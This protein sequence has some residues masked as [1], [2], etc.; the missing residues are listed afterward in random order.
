M[1]GYLVTFIIALIASYLLTPLIRRVA[2]EFK[3]M[4]KPS[5]SEIKTHLVATPYLG[6]VAIYFSFVIAL[7]LATIFLHLSWE[8][9]YIVLISGTIIMFMGLIDDISSLSVYLRFIIQIVI[10]FVLILFNIRIMFISPS[11][12]GMFL[13][14]LWVVGITNAFNIIDIMDGL[15]AGVAVIASMALLF[16]ALPTEQIYVNF[17]A[18]ALAGSTLGFLKYNFF[19]RK[20]KKALIFMGDAGSLFIGFILA[21]LSMGTSYTKMNDIALFSPLLILGIPIYDTFFVM[22]LRFKQGKPIFHGS[23]DHVALRL[24]VLGFN[25]KQVVLI[26]YGVSALLSL[27][28][29]LLTN[30]KINWAIYIYLFVGAV[31]VIGAVKLGKIKMEEKN[32]N[33]H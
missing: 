2:I 1:L 14:V 11:Y 19:L 16:I 13:T 4:D 31:S 18:A 25:R 3:I 33:V 6:G 9:I 15:S 29:L 12:I 7:F 28:A 21:A 20:D 22:L 17:A 23:R 27:V 24:E 5:S 30:V 26:I 10:A 32:N 8:D